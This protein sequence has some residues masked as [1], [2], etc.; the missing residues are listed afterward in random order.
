MGLFLRKPFD[1]DELIFYS[2]HDEIYKTEEMDYF[3]EYEIYKTA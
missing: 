1:D 2:Y 3:I